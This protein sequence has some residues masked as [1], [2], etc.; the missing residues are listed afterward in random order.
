MTLGERLRQL[1]AMKSLSQDE[2]GQLANVPQSVIS[3]VE[4]GR[5][6]T[7]SLDTAQRLAEALGVTLDSLAWSGEEFRTPDT[8][9]QGLA[10][11]PGPSAR[12]PPAE[13]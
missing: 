13:L 5:P 1:R 4:S 2:L 10:E 11:A 6:V 3:D 12:T 8:H 7:L 9:A